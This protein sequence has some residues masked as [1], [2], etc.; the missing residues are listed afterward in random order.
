MAATVT[1]FEFCTIHHCS[2]LEL[3]SE[4]VCAVLEQIQKLTEIYVNY[5]FLV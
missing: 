2:S 3:N 1:T 4:A 5:D